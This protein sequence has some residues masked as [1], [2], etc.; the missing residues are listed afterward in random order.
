MTKITVYDVNGRVVEILVNE[1]LL[2]GRYEV[3]FDASNL[4]SGV[5]FCKIQAEEFTSVKKMVL[6]K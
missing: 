5:Y 4:A 1:N 2:A 6:M 3:D